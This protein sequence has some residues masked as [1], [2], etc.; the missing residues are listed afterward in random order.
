MFVRSL[1][2]FSACVFVLVIGSVS[3]A[4]TSAT[5]D[6][7]N[8]ASAV[9]NRLNQKQLYEIKYKLKPGDQ[10]DWVV[11]HVVSTKVQMAGST[12][13]SSSR[14]ETK[15]RWV[16][17]NIDSLGNITFVHSITGIKM[18]Q[19]IGEDEP[20]AYDSARD[21]DVPEEYEGV[22]NKVGKTL[23][24]FSIKPDGEIVDRQ[25]DLQESSFGTGEVTIPLPKKPVAVGYRWNV[26]SI[27]N[28]TDETGTARKLKARLLYELS[29]VE[30]QNAF[31]KFRTEVL[32][33]IKSEKIKSTIMQQMTDGFI[34][35]DMKLGRPTLKRVE[36]DEKAQGFEG[37]DSLLTYVGRMS[38]KIIVA[39]KV[40]S[41]KP[42]GSGLAPMV[43]K[44]QEKVEL[45][46]RD[47]KPVMRK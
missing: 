23:A 38:E 5:K 6:K 19:K 46:T 11:E 43:A 8:Y 36:W 9:A 40:S 7:K 42:I 37:A 25:S 39:D 20:V 45:K 15:K 24:V 22:A 2:L 12:E 4:Q 47:G 17:R 13:E 14:S 16:V 1:C 18:W 35:F 3:E 31:I 26:P 33:P 32:T 28:A 44:Q 41:G 21:E 34:V 29:K 10:I 27:L 30:G